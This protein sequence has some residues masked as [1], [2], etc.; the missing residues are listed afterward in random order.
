VAR[1]QFRHPIEN[2]QRKP[3][4]STWTPWLLTAAHGRKIS[5]KIWRKVAAAMRIEWQIGFWIGAF[6]LLVALL[7]LFS[8]VLL[9]FVAGVA[10]GTPLTGSRSW[11]SI[12]SSR[13][14]SS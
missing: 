4:N 10:L 12:G 5:S 6:L 11:V 1:S 13:R 8:G 9:P 14:F 2:L 3:A 7:W